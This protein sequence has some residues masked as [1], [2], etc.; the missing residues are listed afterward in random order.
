MKVSEVMTRGVEI[1]SPDDTLRQAAGRMAELDTGALPVGE[2]DLLVGMLTD[3]DSRSA[4]WRRAGV[5]R[6]RCARR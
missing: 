2:G 6:P 3:R 1:A 5:P 4:P